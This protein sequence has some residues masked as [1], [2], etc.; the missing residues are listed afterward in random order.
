MSETLEDNWDDIPTKEYIP[1]EAWANFTGE[2][3]YTH[4]LGG[5]EG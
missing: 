5:E 4:D 1:E 3:E 2:W